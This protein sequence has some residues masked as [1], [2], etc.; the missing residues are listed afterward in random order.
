MCR[1]ESGGGWGDEVMCYDCIVTTLGGV[2]SASSAG[3]CLGA[4]PINVFDAHAAD[5]SHV[6]LYIAIISITIYLLSII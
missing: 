1:L 6:M 5:L 2:D 3:L 4:K